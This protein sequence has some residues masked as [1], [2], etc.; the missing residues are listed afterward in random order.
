MV[1]PR[2]PL[3]LRPRLVHKLRHVRHPQLVQAVNRLPSGGVE[4]AVASLGQQRAVAGGTVQASWVCLVGE[5]QRRAEA[6]F[7]AD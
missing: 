4:H 1:P 7:D 5:Q 3:A 6:A 2:I